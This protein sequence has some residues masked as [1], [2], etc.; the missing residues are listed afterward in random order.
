MVNQRPDR[1][2]GPGHNEFWE[3]CNRDELRLQCCN[4]CNSLMWPVIQN[5]ENCGHDEFN[6]QAMS[7]RGKIVSWCSFEHDYYKGMFKIPHDTI[8]VELEEGPLFISNP[9]NFTYQDA[10][11]EMPVKVTFLECND[12][13]G[14]FK[15]PVFEKA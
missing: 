13:A 8:L 15:L 12:S 10:E 3:W 9:A 5:C 4:N 6:W 1:I 7:G 14:N 11:L 2:L